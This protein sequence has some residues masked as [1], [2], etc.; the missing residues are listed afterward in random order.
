MIEG[1]AE[2]AAVRDRRVPERRCVACGRRAPQTEFVRF[3]LHPG[4]EPPVVEIEH[5]GP[6]LGRGAYMCPRRVCF[7]RAL[8]RRAFQ[9]VFR[10]SVV[11]EVEKLHAEFEAVIGEA[12]GPMAGERWRRDGSTR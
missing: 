12:T 1:P 4:G 5:E 2:V 10:R 3:R 8:H 9:R 7:D 6:R 11:V